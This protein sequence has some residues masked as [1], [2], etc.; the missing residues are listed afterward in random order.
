MKNILFLSLSILS[1]FALIYSCSAEEEDTSP[2]PTVTQPQESEPDPT[3]YTLT[4]TA[5][6]GGTVSTEGGTYDE[7]TSVTITATPKEGYKFIGWSDGESTI[8]RS[9]N[10]SENINIEANFQLLLQ[11]FYQFETIPLYND[12]GYYATSSLAA[13]LDN[14]G[15]EELI[16]AIQKPESVKNSN[17]RQKTPIKVLSFTNQKL[18]DV[19]NNFFDEIP[20]F[21]F[22]RQI[23]FEDLNHDGLKDLYFANHGS[24]PDDVSV[25]YHQELGDR[26]D[27]I[28]CEKD[29]VYVNNGGFFEKADYF[30]VSDYSHGVGI[31]DISGNGKNSILRNE[32]S[33]RPLQLGGKNSIIT[34]QNGNFATNDIVADIEDNLFE[35]YFCSGSLWVYPIDIDSDGIDEVVTQ[36]KIFKITG[37]SYN[38]SDLSPGIYEKD[39]FFINEGGFVYDIDNDGDD[40]LIKS[41]SKTNSNCQLV[42]F[43]DHQL[44]Y[45]ENINGQLNP[46]TGKL[47][48]HPLNLSKFFKPFD[49]NFDGLLDIVFYSVTMFNDPS[50]YFMNN[51]NEFE[52][53]EFNLDQF[54]GF[55][56]FNGEQTRIQQFP[57][58]QYSWFLKSNEGYIFVTGISRGLM[59]FKITNENINLFL[60]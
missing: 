12:G 53:K 34:F 19:T 9:I 26:I 28:W 5:G 33:P 32:P 49:V 22:T 42:N 4:V 14:D 44:E 21:Y 11:G 24:E 25:F 50:F 58:L 6:E 18:V 13:D 36:N 20:A 35:E 8:S 60:K 48:T 54:D 51:G 56:N 46:N 7:G 10:M 3:Q 27:G 1:I 41:A 38:S 16:I 59:A 45:Y 55:V 2:P 40:D 23:F 30:N 37:D 57:E 47:P 15:N 39:D 43:F 52:L 31:I 17:L 29:V